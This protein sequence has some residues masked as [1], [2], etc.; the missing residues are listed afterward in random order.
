MAKIKKETSGIIMQI[1][2]QID[3]AFE[4]DVFNRLGL[5]KVPKIA[6]YIFVIFMVCSPIFGICYLIIFDEDEPVPRRPKRQQ[7]APGGSQAPKEG[8]KA[9]SSSK[10]E[11]LD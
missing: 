7:V 4:S 10:R 5:N 1:A 2:K 6:R 8:E 3:I 11:K 9:A